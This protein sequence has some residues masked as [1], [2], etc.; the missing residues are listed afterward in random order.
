MNTSMK[1][2]QAPY[3]IPQY[4]V[5]GH[6]FDTGE[7]AK[8]SHVSLKCAAQN[9]DSMMIPV[10]YVKPVKII[11][12]IIAILMPF[13]TLK[14]SKYKRK[15]ASLLKNIVGQVTRLERKVSM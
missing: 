3:T 8:G 14:S 1:I 7:P 15:I 11:P 4:S 6:R 10:Q 13:F 2:A 12:V 9:I 5:L